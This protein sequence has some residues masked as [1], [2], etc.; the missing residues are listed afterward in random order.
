MF[1]Q[2][3][4]KILKAKIK[5]ILI[6]RPD[7]IGDCILITPAISAL[8]Q[9]FPQAKIYIL[10]QELTKAVFSTNP[11]I[12]QVFTDKNAIEKNKFDLSVHF[13][14]EMPYAWLAFKKGI[15]YRLGDTSKPL[16]SWLYNLKSTQ[17][18]RDITKHDVEQN[19]LLLKPLGINPPY[20]KLAIY[21]DPDALKKVDSLL[22]EHGISEND[23]IAGLHLSTGKGNKPWSPQNFGLIANYLIKQGFKVVAAG[24]E[25]D[26]ELIKKAKGPII[27]LSTKTNLK[28]LIALISKYKIFISVDT[29]PFH[30][31][32]ALGIPTVHISTSKF[33]LPLRWG[34]WKNPHVLV[35]KKSSCPLFCLPSNCKENI[36]AEEITVEDVKQAI[37][38]L[39]AGKGNN[40]QEQA[41]VDWCKKSF[42]IMIA[43]KPQNLKRAQAISHFGFNCILVNIEDKHDYQK[44][45][46]E[47]N[48]NILHA[49]DGS[50]KLR[51]QALIS[52]QSVITPVLYVKDKPEQQNLLEFYCQAFA[53][54][55]I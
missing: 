40:T 54:T 41:F 2:R 34:P 12:E 8:K 22:K 29:G 5:N 44:L 53:G 14:N 42:N 3:K 26:K 45:F 31:A 17:N 25:K 11:D 50:L 4:L 6:I 32:A 27:D 52:G 19:L 24:Q 38:K 13:Y 43:Y 21:P 35:R 28:E 39:L 23:K 33:S 36:C 48:I 16:V 51:F 9:E 47:N 30:I 55:R 37:D 18:W 1:M 15:K 49:V 20:P 7:A 10:A 46:K